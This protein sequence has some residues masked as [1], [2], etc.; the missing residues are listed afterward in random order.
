MYSKTNLKLLLSF[1]LVI[2]ILSL[3]LGCAAK[4]PFWGDEKT[5]FLLTYRLAPNQVWK[6]H[7]T[8][9]ELTNME[10]MGQAIETERNSINDYSVTGT[11]TDSEN[12]LVA[13]IKIDTIG[14]ASTGMGREMSFDMTPLIGK[15]F[16]MTF[17]PRGKELEFPGADT[18]EVDFGMMAGGKQNVK[19]FFRT[20]FPDLPAKPIKIGESWTDHD[21]LTIPQSGMEI[22]VTT[23]SNNTISGFETIAGMEC[24]KISS[25]ATGAMSG[26]GE[27]MGMDMTFEG[28][29]EGNS[30]WYF[31]YKK[32]TY[33]KVES[34]GFMEGTIAISGAQNMTMPITVETKSE[35]K[36]LK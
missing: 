10:R 35:V 1:S 24:L 31:A 7:S 12:N 20:I 17:S 5:G 13:T 26:G 28:D 27:T 25:K 23:A 15:S 30:T 14:I 36:L 4:K 8:S 34:E 29:I 2:L 33:V 9:Q 32:G 18:L 16:G 6:Y 3:L 21:T 19:N 22:T 11:G